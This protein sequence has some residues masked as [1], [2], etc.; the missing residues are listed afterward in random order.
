MH[1]T[2]LHNRV[3]AANMR[4]GIAQGPVAVGS[5][6]VRMLWADMQTRQLFVVTQLDVY[7]CGSAGAGRC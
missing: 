2:E 6:K 7:P 4:R 5:R 1:S 3:A